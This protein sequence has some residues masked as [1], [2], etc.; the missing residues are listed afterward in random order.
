MEVAQP[1]Q[2]RLTKGEADF[3]F[4][5]VNVSHASE[6][7]GSCLEVSGVE[8]DGFKVL[9]CNSPAI[10]NAIAAILIHLRDKPATIPHAY[11]GW[12]EGN[13]LVC[14]FEYIFFCEGETAPVTREILRELERSPERRPRI[15]VG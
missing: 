15:H 8:I 3:S 4:L 10:P 12:T 13:P 2:C 7:S 9:R 11:F 14:V 6:F 1:N 5:E